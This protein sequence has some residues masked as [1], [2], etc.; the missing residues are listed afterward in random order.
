MRAIAVI[1]RGQKKKHPRASLYFVGFLHPSSRTLWGTQPCHRWPAACRLAGPRYKW[2][3]WCFIFG[4]EPRRWKKDARG[5]NP[6]VALGTSASLSCRV[7]KNCTSAYAPK[8]A[9]TLANPLAAQRPKAAHA[10][11][12]KLLQRAS[13]YFF[14]GSCCRTT[15]S[16]SGRWVAL[17]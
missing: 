16:A 11:F 13:G 7:K 5:K 6:L 4:N 10:S 9:S 1:L 8:S 3:A 15:K 2:L 12:R 17:A 14:E